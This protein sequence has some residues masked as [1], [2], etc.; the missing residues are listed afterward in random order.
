MLKMSSELNANPM[1]CKGRPS[2]ETNC[3][4]VVMPTTAPAP[5]NSG[6]PLFPGF[7]EASVRIQV[8]GSLGIAP[9][10]LTMPCVTLFGNPLLGEPIAMTELPS[11]TPDESLLIEARRMVSGRS[12]QETRNGQGDGAYQG[13]NDKQHTQSRL[14]NML[15]KF[16]GDQ[17]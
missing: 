9:V 10:E 16:C 8:P 1:P 15:A 4:C 5:F 17:K 13:Q 14:D 6:P 7:I 3:F 2:L 12:L 11:R